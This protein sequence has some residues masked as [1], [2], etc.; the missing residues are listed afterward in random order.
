MIAFL[1]GSIVALEPTFAVVAVNGVGYHLHISLHSYAAFKDKKEALFHTHL[2][3]REDGHY[4]YGFSNPEEKRAF[5]HLISVNGVG[6]GTG[7]TI[8]SYLT[9]EELRN[10]ILREDVFALQR[11][12]GIGSKTAQRMIIE[13]KDK[14]LRDPTTSAVSIS[15]SSHNTQREE[16]LSALITLGIP[17]ASAEKSVD[18][19]LKRSGNTITLEDLVKQALKNN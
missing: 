12:K 2:N 17:R 15:E 13:L 5:Q 18:A 6:P 14:L 8:L 9:V 1:K 7:I 4:L 10:A 16:A 11:V 19:V 3:I